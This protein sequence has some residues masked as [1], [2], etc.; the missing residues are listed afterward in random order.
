YDDVVG[1]IGRYF[2]QRLQE[3]TD[4]GIGADRLA[5]DPGI[6]FGKTRDHNLQLLA[7]LPAFQSF[8]RPV[9][10]GVSRK[11]FLGKLLNCDVSRRLAS[12]LAVACHAMLRGGAQI[13]RVHDVEET[14]D[15]LTTI[16]AIES[17]SDRP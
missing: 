1:D 5:L 11:G 3:L 17:F 6:G 12:S 10:L 16:E 9:C 2:E 7:R 15:A 8:G 13:V 14:R 4:L